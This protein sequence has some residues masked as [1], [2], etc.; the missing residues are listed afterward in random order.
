MKQEDI[1]KPYEEVKLTQMLNSIEK[2]KHTEK[3]VA[4]VIDP[5]NNAYTFFKYKGEVIDMTEHLLKENMGKQ[6]R[7]E[8]I[9]RAR[10]RLYVGL[11]SGATT[12]IA[13]DKVAKNL[14]DIFKGSLWWEPDKLFS[15]EEVLVEEF[16][17]KKIIKKEEDVDFEGNKGCFLAKSDFT[18]AILISEVEEIDYKKIVTELGISPNL[19][20]I[21]RIIP[22]Q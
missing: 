19:L 22:N 14:D 18:L 17:K 12:I 3:K 4:L 21:V 9:E 7:E 13:M 6:T 8:S 5:E 10:M 11:K 2:V 20:K 1:Y 16:Y 15:P